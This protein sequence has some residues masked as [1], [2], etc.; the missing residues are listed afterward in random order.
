MRVGNLGFF[1]FFW[2]EGSGYWLVFL[3]VFWPER[4]CGVV[5]LSFYFPSSITFLLRLPVESGKAQ[6][7]EAG[8]LRGVELTS[9]VRRKPLDFLL[10]CPSQLIWD[11]K[12]DKDLVGSSIQE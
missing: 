8:R 11:R 5:S 6:G 2:M 1:F 12:R 4:F 3:E 10:T 7:R 9:K